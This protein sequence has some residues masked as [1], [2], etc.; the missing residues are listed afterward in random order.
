MGVRKIVVCL[1]EET[2]RVSSAPGG[3]P[4]SWRGIGGVVVEAFGETFGE[5]VGEGLGEPGF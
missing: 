5:G 2:N 1:S 3:W 4:F